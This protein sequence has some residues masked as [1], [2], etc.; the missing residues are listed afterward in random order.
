M[1]LTHNYSAL[2]LLLSCES[3]DTFVCRA[4]LKCLETEIKILAKMLLDV[5]ERQARS[6]LL[7]DGVISSILGQ[8]DD[9]ISFTPMNCKKVVNPDDMS[10]L[11]YYTII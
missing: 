4:F 6:T 10:G 7:P 9:Q 8:P 3:D 2:G 5:F 11:Q 1:S